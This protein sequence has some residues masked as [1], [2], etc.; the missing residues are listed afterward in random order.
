MAA[1]L[2]HLQV[3]Q[4][5]ASSAHCSDS[6]TRCKRYVFSSIDP[7]GLDREGIVAVG[8]WWV[9]DQYGVPAVTNRR[10]HNQVF[11]LNSKG[12]LEDQQSWKL[13]DLLVDGGYRINMGFPQSPEVKVCC[14]LEGRVGSRAELEIRRVSYDIYI[15]IYIYI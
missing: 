15:Y 7:I 3:I 14:E 11:T 5:A 1:E 12:R 2:M 9:Q 13:G 10:C 6:C 4:H 8:R